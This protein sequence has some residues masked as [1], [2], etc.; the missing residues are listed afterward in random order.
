M[1]MIRL[2]DFSLKCKKRQ[3]NYRENRMTGVWAR[4]AG[5]FESEA[6]AGIYTHVNIHY[7]KGID[8]KPSGLCSK[9]R[10]INKC[11]VDTQTMAKV[12]E[13]VYRQD[14]DKKDITIGSKKTKRT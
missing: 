1:M 2:F 5:T 9:C 13:C 6:L 3:E 10:Y 11:V 8:L 4:W 12:I 7:K 14:F